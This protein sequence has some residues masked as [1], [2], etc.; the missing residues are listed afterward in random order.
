MDPL[1]P[2]QTR[3]WTSLWRARS[4]P[5]PPFTYYRAS[6]GGDP[7][8]LNASAREIAFPND[9][10]RAALR[11]QARLK[12]DEVRLARKVALQDCVAWGRC[13]GKFPAG[14]APV[15]DWIHPEAVTQSGILE[16]GDLQGSGY[17]SQCSQAFR[18]GLARAK[19][20]TWKSLPSYFE[21]PP[22]SDIVRQLP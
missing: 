15:F 16:K 6:V 9:I 18:K 11:G 21:L 10:L 13:S 4:H 7:T 5:P 1:Y 20:D 14:R 3:Y 19:E 17:C 22:W 8:S 2:I 12:T